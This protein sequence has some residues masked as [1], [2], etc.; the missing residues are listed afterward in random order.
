MVLL[1]LFA[2]SAPA[3]FAEQEL[4][5]EGG[6][7]YKAK[8]W[9]SSGHL[10]VLDH[11]KDRGMGGQWQYWAPG[12]EGVVEQGILYWDDI[13][14]I[15]FLDNL[16][17][18]NYGPWDR[19]LKRG[20]RAR[21]RY[22]NGETRELY[23]HVDALYGKDAY[24]TRRVLGRTVTRVDFLETYRPVVRR[25]PNGHVWPEDGY[26]F[27]PYDGQEVTKYEQY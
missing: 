5:Y 14:W 11:M 17:P 19:D 1:A 6:P 2:L 4:S 12:G 23:V 10:W 27:C 22:N 24:G 20:R 15:T 8:V 18:Y 3:A 25:C 9:A 26:N 13:D 7:R 16:E 21:V